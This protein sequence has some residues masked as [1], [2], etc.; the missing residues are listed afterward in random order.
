MSELDLD[1]LK[2]LNLP[3]VAPIDIPDDFEVWEVSA[4]TDSIGGDGY[5]I[6]IGRGDAE[7]ELRAVSRKEDHP[8]GE[9]IEREVST[10]FFGLFNLKRRGDELV[11]DWFSEMQ[12]GF[13]AYNVRAKGVKPEEVVEFIHSLDYVRVN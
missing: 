13:P 3:I 10:R 1:N 8:G 4:L 7:I 2:G 9:F 12:S 5:Q 11:S 6:R